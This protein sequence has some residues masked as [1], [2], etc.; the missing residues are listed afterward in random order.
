MAWFLIRIDL[1]ENGKYRIL[2]VPQKN[3]VLT[4]PVSQTQAE[5]FLI[6]E[7]KTRLAKGDLSPFE[8]ASFKKR[9]NKLKKISIDNAFAAL[10]ILACLEGNL[11][12]C[13][14]NHENSIKYTRFPSVH[15][16]NYANSLKIMGLTEEAIELAQRARKA[17][18]SNMTAL[19]VAIRASFDLG[20]ENRYLFFASEWRKL[21]NEDHPS[22]VDYLA[23]VKEA[24]E[25][26]ACC[27]Y[28]ALHVAEGC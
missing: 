1:G 6:D 20:D 12:E 14:K 22:F 21:M 24:N 28:G 26:T 17:D 7:I 27:T 4:V 8:L 3:G 19:D 16:A 25:L 2:V 15:L 13:R 9:A 23:E 18:M 11:E 5:T 10:G